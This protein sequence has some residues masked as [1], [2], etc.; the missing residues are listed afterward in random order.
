MHRTL[1]PS[2]TL[3]F[4]LRLHVRPITR[5][6]WCVSVALDAIDESGRGGLCVWCSARRRV[7]LTTHCI[8]RAPPP[9]SPS[10]CQQAVATLTPVTHSL[11]ICSCS[12]FIAASSRP[13][14]AQQRQ[15]SIGTLGPP[16]ELNT[17]CAIA[18]S[19]D[20]I[21]PPS[22]S[23]RHGL[24]SITP[25]L[26]AHSFFRRALIEPRYSSLQRR[27]R[28]LIGHRHRTSSSADA[29]PPRAAPGRRA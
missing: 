7:S 5:S 8:S 15:R 21:P 14:R 18:A 24:A 23:G 9:T 3:R 13:G 22:C 29:Q 11:P 10:P 28:T 20:R 16:I 26:R 4:R 2:Q 1:W 27:L 17:S 6:P 19:I 25:P 12:T